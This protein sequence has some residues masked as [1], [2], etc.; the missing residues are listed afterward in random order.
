[1]KYMEFRIEIPLFSPIIKRL[2]AIEYVGRL[3]E[4]V[5]IRAFAPRAGDRCFDRVK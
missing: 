5:V 1:M 2:I 4:R 3:D